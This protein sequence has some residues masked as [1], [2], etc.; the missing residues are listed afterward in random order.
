MKFSQCI[1][2]SKIRVTCCCLLKAAVLSK[3][4]MKE[5]YDQ[6]DP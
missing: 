6:H 2:T 4:N 1:V 5:G 3:C